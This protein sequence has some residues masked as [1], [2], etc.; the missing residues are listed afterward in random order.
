MTRKWQ[1]RAIVLVVVGVAMFLF[2][3]AGSGRISRI[4]L[5]IIGDSMERKSRGLMGRAGVDCGMVE[6]NG[7]PRAATDCALKADQDGRPFRVRYN[8]MGYDSAVAGGIVRTPTGELY[9]LSFDGDPAGQ[10]GISIFREALTVN[11]CPQPWHLWVNPKGRLN[12]F[13]Q[14]LSPPAGI[15]SPNFEPY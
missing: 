14:Q 12:C 4:L 7:D 13:Q 15:T 8:I 11:A 5:P 10:G 9:A 2:V 6:V 1:K 3:G